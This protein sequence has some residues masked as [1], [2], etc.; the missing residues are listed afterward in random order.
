MKYVTH[1]KVKSH[2]EFNKWIN[3]SK[4]KRK[5]GKTRK[6]AY[7]PFHYI[8]VNLCL[9]LCRML[10]Y[11]STTVLVF[12]VILMTYKIGFSNFYVPI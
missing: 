9:F 5:R 7:L 3:Q 6:I 8:I 4:R 2:I 11:V 1:D 10:V 12:Y